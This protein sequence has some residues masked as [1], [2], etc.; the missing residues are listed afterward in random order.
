MLSWASGK[1]IAR[2]AERAPGDYSARS[3]R[4]SGRESGDK[5]NVTFVTV[6][7]APADLVGAAQLLIENGCQNQLDLLV[8]SAS[9]AGK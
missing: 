7:N 8:E 1:A 5:S 2:L 6:P 3:I 9:K 4:S